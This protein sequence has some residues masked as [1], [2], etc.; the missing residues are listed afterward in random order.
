ML[1][2]EFYVVVGGVFAWRSPTVNL[3]GYCG[4]DKETPVLLYVSAHDAERCTYAIED[5]LEL[6]EVFV[7]G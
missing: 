6:F 5:V 4:A 3:A 2:Y 7:F 1:A